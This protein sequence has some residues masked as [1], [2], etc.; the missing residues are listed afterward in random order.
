MKR[1]R[2]ACLGQDLS[3]GGAER[4]QLELLKRLDRDSF[5]IDLCYLRD[6]GDLYDLVPAD[7]VPV[8]FSPGQLPFK[9]GVCSAFKKYKAIARNAD[10]L[11]GMMDGIP[12][13]LASLVGW[14]EDKAS[15]GWV[16]NTTS[17]CFKDCNHLHRYLAP[18]FYPRASQLVSVSNGARDDLRQFTTLSMLTEYETWRLSLCLR[19]WRRGMTSRL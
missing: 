9:E 11:F 10:V 16:H 8:F 2:I 15:I 5:S 13:Y 4:V 6:R 17:I 19:D 12:I 1:I 7:L 18:I 3:G 14:L